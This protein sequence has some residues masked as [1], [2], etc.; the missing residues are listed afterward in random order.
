MIL[1]RRMTIF[2]QEDTKIVKMQV[3]SWIRVKSIFIRNSYDDKFSSSINDH[4]HIY[5]FQQFLMF[6]CKSFA[7]GSR[8]MLRMICLLMYHRLFRFQQ[9]SVEE[10]VQSVRSRTKHVSTSYVLLIVEFLIHGNE[11]PWC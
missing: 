8:I 3:I 7:N 9:A 11:P 2:L 4:Y 6:F 1:M 10:P 5:C